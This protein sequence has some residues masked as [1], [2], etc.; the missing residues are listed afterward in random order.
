MLADVYTLYSQQTPHSLADDD[1]DVAYLGNGMS[2]CS[3]KAQ[4]APRTPYLRCLIVMDWRCLNKL[5]WA[6]AKETH[7]FG[8]PQARDVLKGFKI[9]NATNWSL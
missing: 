6:G 8:G 3:Q 4:K 7:G 1:D 9:A 5:E 2:A